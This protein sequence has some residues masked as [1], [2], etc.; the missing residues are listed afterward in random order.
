MWY[1][2]EHNGHGLNIEITE[3]AEGEGRRQTVFVII[4][5]YDDE[6]KANF[7][8]GN[9]DYERWRADESMV[10]DMLQTVGG[11]FSSLAPIDFNNPDDVQPAG[12]ADLYFFDCENAHIDFGLNERGSAQP[13]EHSIDLV[14]LIGV[15]VHVCEAASQALP[16]I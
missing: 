2:P 3:F 16:D 12:Q 14:K 1:S 9:R 8:A 13:V 15:P 7:Y 6:G 4:Y 10:V 11:D 5:T